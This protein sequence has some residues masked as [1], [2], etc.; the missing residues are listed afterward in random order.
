MLLYLYGCIIWTKYR[1]NCYRGSVVA[2]ETNLQTDG[3][4]RHKI[5]SSVFFA[6]AINSEIA[7]NSSL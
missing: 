5:E 1:V 4:C 3:C 7:I 2:K 6:E